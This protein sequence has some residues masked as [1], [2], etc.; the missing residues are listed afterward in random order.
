[1]TART[2]NWI[3]GTASVILVVYLAFMLLVNRQQRATRLCEGIYIQVIDSAKQNFVTVEELTR[4]LGRLPMIARKTPVNSINTDSLERRLRVIDKIESVS[5]TRLTDGSMHIIVEP[6][7]PVARVFEPDRSYYINKDGK[8]MT[9]DARYHVDVPVIE[10]FF[11]DSFFTATS[12][13][14]LVDFIEHSP[15]WRNLTTMIRVDPPHDIIIVPAVRGIVF[16]IGDVSNLPDKFSRLERMMAEVL[17]SAGWNRYDTI[18]VKW[19]GQAVATLRHKARRDS[20][21][22]AEVVK[23]DDDLETMTV[24]DGIAAGQALPG[25]KATDAKKA[26]PQAPKE[27]PADKAPKPPKD[28][29]AEKP[30]TNKSN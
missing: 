25:K 8:S 11:P 22:T 30:K 12:L 13:L 1:M 26:K 4:E 23:E 10:G 20:T 21:M 9:A 15:R 5:V 16:N 18:S 29:A 19:K 2:K 6:M 27:S 17:P 14:P 7:R 28:K 3:Y 24:G